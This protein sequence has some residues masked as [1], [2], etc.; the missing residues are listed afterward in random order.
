MGG[1]Y[2]PSVSCDE[3]LCLVAMWGPVVSVAG[4]RQD[5]ILG[6]ELGF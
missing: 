6:R 1:S 5:C 4:E 2:L 3:F